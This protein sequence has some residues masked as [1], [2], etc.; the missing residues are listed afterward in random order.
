M[1]KS[2]RIDGLRLTA[3]LT[4]VSMAAAGCSSSEST[5]TQCWNPQ[6]PA[7]S[8]TA[9]KGAGYEI[10]DLTQLGADY[11][12]PIKAWIDNEPNPIDE[13]AFAS[14]QVPGWVRNTPRR[15]IFDYTRTLGSPSVPPGPLTP[16]T[17]P[18]GYTWGQIAEVRNFIWPFDPADYPSPPPSSGWEA[19]VKSGTSIPPGA[20]IYT[21]NNKNQDLI[22]VA[23][24]PA[25][26]T[27]IKRYFVTD[28]W[29]NVFIMKSVNSANTTEELVD[30]A[31]A[32]AQLPEG[33]TK[34]TRFLER[35]L[36]VPPIYG[37]DNLAVFQE[38]RDSTDSA[39]SQIT[40]APNGNGVARL[41]GAPMPIWAGSNGSRVNGSDGDDLMYGGPGND[42]FHPGLGND[43]IDGGAGINAVVLDEAQGAYTVTVDGDV[44]RLSGPGGQKTLRRIQEIRYRDGIVR[45]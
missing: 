37:G 28:Q 10:F 42:V 4:L 22:F 6:D 24:D 8:S 7:Y 33:W 41:I 16:Y 13:A 34:S 44:T 23:R 18:L 5:A 1:E 19:G 14:Y 20:V 30:R 25:T 27:P 17:D 38:L 45:L 21:A 11:T 12:G 43:T 39:Y 2:M 40:W 26:G 9:A 36:C 31:F 32:D 29:G 35:D 3:L 15:A